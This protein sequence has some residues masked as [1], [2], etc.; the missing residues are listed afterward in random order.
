MHAQ[1]GAAEKLILLVWNPNVVTWNIFERS[2]SFHWR[3]WFIFD[4]KRNALRYINAHMLCLTQKGL[5]KVLEKRERRSLCCKGLYKFPLQ[6]LSLP[7]QYVL[8]EF[9]HMDFSNRGSYSSMHDDAWIY[10]SLDVPVELS[11]ASIHLYIRPQ[12]KFSE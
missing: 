6:L 9:S 1:T 2:Y 11:Y 4:S 12:N 10:N 8:G 3:K 7:L 5:I